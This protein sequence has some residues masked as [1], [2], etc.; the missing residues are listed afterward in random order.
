VTRAAGGKSFDEFAQ[1]YIDGREPFPYASVLPL[2]GLAFHADSTRLPRL[3]TTTTQDSTGIRVTAVTPASAASA[4]G[5]QE[6]DYL[7]K[8]G[9]VDV[10]TAD[11]GLAFRSRYAREPEGTPLTIVLRRKDQPLTLTASLR[12]ATLTSYAIT[13]DQ[14]AAAK[15]T[16]IRDGILQGALSP[17]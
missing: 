16:R 3:G 1:L 14:N 17:P 15:A 5:V 6:G 4:A 7:L 10:R 2:A 12:F 11:F 13:A 9:D 8:V